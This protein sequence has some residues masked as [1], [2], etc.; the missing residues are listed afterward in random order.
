YQLIVADEEFPEFQSAQLML[1]QPDGTG[2]VL[3]RDE[4]YLYALVADLPA[5]ELQSLAYAIKGT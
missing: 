5:A 3:W 4:N 1:L 2:V